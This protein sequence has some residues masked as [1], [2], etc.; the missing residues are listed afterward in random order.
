[1]FLIYGILYFFD[2]AYEILSTISYWFMCNT[3]FLRVIDMFVS[4]SDVHE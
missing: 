1:M 3:F 2:D 4:F